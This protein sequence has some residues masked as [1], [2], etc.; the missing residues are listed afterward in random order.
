MF[1]CCFRE[2]CIE[3]ESIALGEAEKLLLPK[4]M[5][6]TARVKAEKSL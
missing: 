2:R 3:E 1:K 6:G 5:T 4:G